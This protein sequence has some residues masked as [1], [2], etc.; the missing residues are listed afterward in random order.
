MKRIIISI[1]FL[2]VSCA[3]ELN[4]KQLT[5]EENQTVSDNM[6]EIQNLQLQLQSIQLKLEQSQSKHS[7]Y[8]AELA[9]KY[10]KVGCNLSLKRDW[11][12]P[13]VKE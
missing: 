1:L 4:K 3:Q 6:L 9:I 13:P 5:T 2:T 8:E 12:C 10:K 7:I 11:I